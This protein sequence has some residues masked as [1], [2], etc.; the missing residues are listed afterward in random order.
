[1]SDF[2]AKIIAQLDTSKIPSQIAQ[3]GKKGIDL[4]NVRIKNAQMDTK[5]LTAQ[6]QAALNKQSFSINLGKVNIGGITNNAAKSISQ[7]LNSRIYSQLNTGQI[8][9]SIAKVTAQYEKLST[10]G[11]AKLTQIQSDIERLNVLNS[12][13]ATTSSTEHLNKSYTEFNTL[14]SRVKNNLTSVSAES[15]MMASSLQVKTLDNKMSVWMQNN[16]KATK[17]F[18]ASI[19]TLRSK[20]KSMSASGTLT[21]TQ[22][23]GIENEFKSVTIAAQQAGKLG[24]TFGDTFKSSFSSITKYV[25]ASTLIFSAVN[26]LRQGVTTVKELDSALIDLQKTAQATASQLTNFYYHANDVAKEYGATTQEII[27]SAADWSRLGYSLNDSKLMAQYSSMFKSISPG[28]DIDTATT[29]LVSVMKAYGIEAEDVLDGVMSKINKI[30]NTAATSND[31]I[32]EGLQQSSAAMATMGSSLDENI[33]LFT[34]AQEITQDASKV[35]NAL[36]SISMRIRGYNEETEELDDSLVNITGDVIDLTKTASNPNGVSLFTD[37]TQTEYKSV[38]TYLQDISKIYDELGAKE[39]QQL[40]EKLFGKNR[41]SVGAALLDNFSAAE[42]AMSDMSNS[43]GSAEAEMATITQSLE[44]KLN[45]L[46]ETSTGIFQNL[47]KKEDFSAVIDVL[48]SVL[49]VVDAVTEKLGLFGT[50]G[51]GIG[52]TAFI[53]NFSQ[54]KELGNLTLERV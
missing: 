29:G 37:E 39:Q 40:L 16:S 47:F 49:E 7:S 38:Y 52:L 15:K 35:G 48:T 46:K 25:S 2:T 19:D 26:T 50:I 21:T 44:Y 13:M 20:L 24:K 41:A 34:A 31:Q 36:R 12:K 18:G 22:L 28:M 14:L 54:L 1:M 53:K 17:D 33:A 43:A 45:A 32:I 11:H 5:G 27:Q 30:G 42:K 51:A 6:V 4:S 10:T 9:A 3:I 8:E 23:K